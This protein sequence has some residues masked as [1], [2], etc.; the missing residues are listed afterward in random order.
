MIR[1]LYLKNLIPEF[2]T[3][4]KGSYNKVCI[5]VLLRIQDV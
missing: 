1:Y 3:Q 2:M 5:V 4:N